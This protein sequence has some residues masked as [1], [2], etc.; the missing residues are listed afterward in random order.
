V[1]PAH[2]DP[3]PETTPL[4]EETEGILLDL[5]LEATEETERELVELPPLH[6]EH[7][8][9]PRL[10]EPR[11]ETEEEHNIAIDTQ[12]DA[13]FAKDAAAFEADMSGKSITVVASEAAEHG[14]GVSAAMDVL[15]GSVRDIPWSKDP[16]NPS[17]RVPFDLKVRPILRERPLEFEAYTLLEEGRDAHAPIELYQKNLEARQLRDGLGSLIETWEEVA[18]QTAEALD[19]GVVVLPNAAVFHTRA[20]PEGWAR[21]TAMEQFR[22]HRAQME[23]QERAQRE[24]AS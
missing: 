2:N 4:A 20:V 21:S 22:L 18:R 8:H 13:E 16:A 17:L 24:Y 1:N 10:V 9:P 7:Q 14:L 3:T 19:L 12:E 5:T 15:D 11:F 23:A 6:L